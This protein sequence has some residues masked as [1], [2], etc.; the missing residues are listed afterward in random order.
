MLQSID[1]TLVQFSACSDATIPARE[2]FPS[3]SLMKL[4]YKIMH[5]L[6]CHSARSI[7]A[8]EKERNTQG[9][10]SLGALLSKPT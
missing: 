5:S 9:N 4:L 10:E 1:D 7:A 2:C 8:P 3:L 6:V